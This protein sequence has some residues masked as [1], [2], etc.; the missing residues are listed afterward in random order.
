[1]AALSSLFQAGPAL[2]L[3]AV[4]LAWQAGVS[5]ALAAEQT[6]WHAASEAGRSVAL[7]LL[8]LAGAPARTDVLSLPRTG[9][10]DACHGRRALRIS[11]SPGCSVAKQTVFNLAHPEPLCAQSAVEAALKLF[12][13][14]AGR[15]GD[16][17]Q[18]DIVTQ[19][20][21]LALDAVPH[22]LRRRSLVQAVAEALVHG[23]LDGNMLAGEPGPAVQEMVRRIRVRE[24]PSFSADG[25]DPDKRALPNTVQLR[26]ASSPLGASATVEYPIGHY[27][28]R[29]EGL[30]LLLAKAESAIAARLDGDR[31]E[32]LID[33]FD[34][35]EVLLS[36]P[37]VRFVDLLV[38]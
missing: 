14:L 1:V 15:Q 18:V 17:A 32:D 4:S 20:A 30:P 28:R 26:F 8:A 3:N 6:A 35:P 7:C 37:V 12:P 31:A 5:P 22:P 24:D 2:A 10:Q 36:M 25:R 11:R 19:Q 23:H 27:R 9:F 38:V 21:G 34:H 13:L 16:L 29:R 33:L